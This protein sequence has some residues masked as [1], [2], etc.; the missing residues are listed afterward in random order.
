MTQDATRKPFDG[1]IDWSNFHCKISQYFTVGEVTKGDSRRIP[2]R[3]SQVETNILTL[4]REMDKIRRDWGRPI[5]VTSWY[6]PSSVNRSVGGV[7]NSQHIEGSAADIYTMDGDE[8]NFERFISRH[9]GGAVGYGVAS[10][11]GFTHIDLRGGSWRKGAG[12]I[13]WNY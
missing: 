9:W 12:E 13:R 2:T 6:R 7:S 1:Q 11:R 10:G 4:A 3:G 8:E 5:G